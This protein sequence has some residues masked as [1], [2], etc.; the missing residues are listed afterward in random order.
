MS[1]GVRWTEAAVIAALREWAQRYGEAPTAIDWDRSTA[2]RHGGAAK[3]ARLVEHPTPVPSTSTV[4]ARF[5]SWKAAIAAADLE[6]RSAAR[7][8]DARVW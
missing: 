2:Y 4:I 8:L 1:D 6:P 5:R 7:R 3:V